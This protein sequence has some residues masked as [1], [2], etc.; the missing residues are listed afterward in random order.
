M[1][2][3]GIIW[4]RNVVDKLAWKHSVT[5]EEVEEIFN[6]APRYRCIEAGDVDG[7]DLY[8]ALG[9]TNA[10]RYLI[11]FFIHKATGE[12]LIVSARAM[13]KKERS[14]YARK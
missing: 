13:T 7:E 10:G 3:T 1:K 12:A 4:L 9:R 6:R 2:V 8:T 11:V 5:T 14:V